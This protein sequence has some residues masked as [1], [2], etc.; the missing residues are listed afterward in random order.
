MLNPTDW[1]ITMAGDAAV[2]IEYP[3]RIDPLISQR[4]VAL[5]ARIR[6]ARH[7]GVRDVVPSYHAVTVYFEP[8]HTDL[9]S[10]WTA[11]EE[12]AE[13][14][15]AMETPSREVIVPVVYGGVDGPDLG[16]VASFSGCTTEEVVRLHTSV[17]YRVYMVGF[18]AG[19]P[20]M[21]TIDSRIAMP[22]REVPRLSVPAG[23]VGIAGIQTG[24]YPMTAPGGWRLIGRT[25]VGRFDP[26]LDSPSFYQPG[27]RVRFRAVEKV[28]AP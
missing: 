2:T 4:V 24:I 9:A 27:D 26:E 1:R 20:Y 5:A 13:L 10:L 28:G 12:E 14:P 19:F 17:L 22:R 6:A 25:A 8:T 11:L 21:G 3:P 7:V 23:S 18:L 15:G 16:E